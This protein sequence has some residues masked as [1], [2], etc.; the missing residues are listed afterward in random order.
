MNIESIKTFAVNDTD[1]FQLLL[2]RQNELEIERRKIRDELREVDAALIELSGIKVGDT[3]PLYH[4]EDRIHVNTIAS[5]VFVTDEHC[6]HPDRVY[7]SLNGTGSPI[8]TNGTPSKSTKH[9]GWSKV[10]DH[11][12]IPLPDYRA[13]VRG[14]E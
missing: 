4:G 1:K 9:R 5:S 11:V 2:Q 14:E 3:I 10:I 7:L 8:T 6:K 13:I 12:W